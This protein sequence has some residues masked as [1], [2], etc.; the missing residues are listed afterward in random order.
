MTLDQLH[1]WA[2]AHPWPTTV[3]ATAALGVTAFTA[4]AVG[5]AIRAMPRPP[6]AVVVAAAGALVCTAYSADAS[7][8]FAEHHLGMTAVTERAVMFAAAELALLAC[9]VMARANKAVTT[10]D[11]EAGTP[12]V[13]GVL[14]WLIT[15]VLVIPC[16]AES[17]LV[18]GTVRA[19]IGPVMAG[20]LWHLAM[21]LEIRLVR[22]EALSTGL[23]ATIG[24][25]LRERLLSRLG[26]AT[27]NR[28]AE[29]ITRDRATARAVRLGARRWL[30]PWG[31]ARLAAALDRSGAATNGEQRHTLMQQLAGRRSAGD[32][33]TVPVVSPWVQQ[34]V[35]E[36]YPRTPLGV[37]GEQLRRMDPIEAILLVHRANLPAG[38]AELAALCTEYGVPV[39]EAQA[40]LALRAGRWGEGPVID[41]STAERPEL[42]AVPEPVPDAVPAPSPAATLTLDL[43]PMPEVHPEVRAPEPVC[44]AEHPRTQVHARVPDPGPEEIVDLIKRRAA[45]E[46]E[47]A[48]TGQ[49][50]PAVPEPS[51]PPG[52]PA[53]EDPLLARAR[54]LDAEYRCTHDGRPV[55]IR[56]LKSGLHIGQTRA[57]Q[58][59]AALAQ[60]G[61]P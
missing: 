36:V 41:P 12:G 5:R 43:A 17:G 25:E 15:A 56:A 23:P 60:G 59:R 20:L 6:A 48:A 1:G 58:V 18:G 55:S 54:V 32:L 3:A 57:K 30:S 28:T 21:G 16:Y 47:Q 33:R 8:R 39:T 10:T 52:T 4:Y 51:T 35:P 22:P 31:K 19:V 29:Q 9:A 14:M 50:P 61:T 37:T 24:R 40:G 13:P 42:S 53:D 7:W 11:G 44:A 34:P 45:E 27:R 38:P 49:P 26:L 2:L 46:R